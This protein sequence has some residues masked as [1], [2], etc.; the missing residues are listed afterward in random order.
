[1]FDDLPGYDEWA[2]DVER[3]RQAGMELD[4]Q[5]VTPALL[6]SS[7]RVKLAKALANKRYGGFVRLMLAE[8]IRKDRRFARRLE[9]QAV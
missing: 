7:T 5:T 1:M 4:W 9:R 8:A 2:S 6:K 3:A